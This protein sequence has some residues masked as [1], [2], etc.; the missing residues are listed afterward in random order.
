MGD[1][2][3]YGPARPGIGLLLIFVTA[4]LFWGACFTIIKSSYDYAIEARA[5]W[6]VCAQLQEYGHRDMT[7]EE[8]V[9][10]FQALP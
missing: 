8:C 7:V 4:L 10:E 1:Y 3:G 2:V 5:Y 6:R 9:R